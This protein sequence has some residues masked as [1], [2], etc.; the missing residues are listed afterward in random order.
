MLLEWILKSPMQIERLYHHA[1]FMYC[2]C[3]SVRQ[4]LKGK[5][6]NSIRINYTNI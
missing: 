4:S 2:D 1:I 6:Q 3:V 5:I